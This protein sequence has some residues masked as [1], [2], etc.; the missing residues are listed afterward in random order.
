VADL[1][2]LNKRLNDPRI[3]DKDWAIDRS[4]VT[5]QGIPRLGQDIPKAV[6][7]MMPSSKRLQCPNCR[8]EKFYIMC[9]DIDEAV[10]FRCGRQS[11]D[12]WWMP[13]GLHKIQMTDAIAKSIGLYIPEVVPS[14]LYQP[15][16]GWE[17]GDFTDLVEEQERNRR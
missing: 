7:K 3:R 5:F 15:L 11:C 9:S 10:Q 6:T 1:E 16:E 14:G 2:S 17:Q 13:A 12:T 8:S 4:G